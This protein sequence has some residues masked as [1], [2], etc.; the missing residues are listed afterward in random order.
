[1]LLLSRSALGRTT[2]FKK[3]LTKREFMRL[4]GVSAVSFVLFNIFKNNPDEDEEGLYN[5]SA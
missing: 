3:Q 2:I 4:L 5:K 1:M